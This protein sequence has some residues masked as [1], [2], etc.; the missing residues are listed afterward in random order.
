M[1]APRLNRAF[2]L[3][4]AARTT[5]DAGGYVEGW[6]PLGTLWAEVT[7][8]SGG[9]VRGGSTPL[10]RVRYRIVVRGAPLGSP[11][12]P[13]PGQ[14]M[15]DG[16]RVYRIEAVGEHDPQGRYLICYANEEIVT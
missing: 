14:R 6:T 7:A 11:Q 1:R 4:Q 10:G 2:V 12:R 16:E 8:R 13:G 5:D 3:E 9:S 15:R